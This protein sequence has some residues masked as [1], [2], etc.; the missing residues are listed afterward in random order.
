MARVALEQADDLTAADVLHSRFD[1]L[2][3][4]ASVADVRAWFAGSEHRELA[5]LANDGMYAGSL[6]RADVNGDIDGQRRADGLARSAPTVSPQAPAMRARELALA[7]PARRL[8][9]VDD[10]GRLIGVVA[11]TP[12]LQGFC[13]AD[14]STDTADPNQ[15]EE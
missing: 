7:A 11:I 1:T 4:S 8:P 2:P 3:G 6:L 14:R 5:L 12:D 10:D 13:G 15:P 9:V